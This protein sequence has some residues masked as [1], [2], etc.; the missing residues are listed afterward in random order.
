M[1]L[2]FKALCICNTAYWLDIDYPVGFV[3]FFRQ[4]VMI[5]FRVVILNGQQTETSENLRLNLGRQLSV[6]TPASN[7]AETHREKKIYFVLTCRT[8]RRNKGNTWN[9]RDVIK[10]IPPPVEWFIV[11]NHYAHC[12]WTDYGAPTFQHINLP[13]NSISNFHIMPKLKIFKKLN[14]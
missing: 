3:N 7:E 6:N 1:T 8:V 11:R 5:I 9:T 10:W 2:H 13:V 4:V 14:F 12:T